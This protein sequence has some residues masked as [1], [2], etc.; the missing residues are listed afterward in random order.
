MFEFRFGSNRNLTVLECAAMVRNI[1]FALGGYTPSEM[2][3]NQAK[4]VRTNRARDLKASP[5]D[6]A[7][8]LKPL[9]EVE[10][11]AI[12]NRVFYFKGNMEAAAR[13]L[14]ISKSQIYRNVKRYG[15]AREHQ[16]HRT[17]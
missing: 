9:R 8:E 7:K 5:D 15:Y 1:E 17:N 11:E 16:W 4:Q 14:K 6:S 12:L 10:R 13:S 2:L 3:E